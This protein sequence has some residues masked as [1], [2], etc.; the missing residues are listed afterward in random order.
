MEE[1]QRKKDKNGYDLL[2]EEEE[3]THRKFLGAF[4]PDYEV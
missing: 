4:L 2:T 3:K 1:K